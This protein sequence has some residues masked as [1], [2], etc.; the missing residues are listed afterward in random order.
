MSMYRHKYSD[1]V[2]KVVFGALVPAVLYL[3]LFL[4]LTYPLITTFSTHLWG[5]AGDGYQNYW[6]LWWVK[7]SLV[8]QRQNP[9]FTTMQHYPYGS[10]L[11]GHP[12]N[13]YSGIVGIGLQ[14]FLTLAQTYNAILMLSYVLAGLTMFWLGKYVTKSW[15]AGFVAGYV[16]T[17]SHHHYAYSQAQLELANIQWLPLY[18]MLFLMFLEKPTKL[19]A[20]LAALSLGLVIS[21]VNYHLVF[22]MFFSLI[23]VVWFMLKKRDVLFIVRKEYLSALLVFVVTASITAGLHIKNIMSYHH[24]DPILGAHLSQDWQLDTYGLFVPGKFWRFRELTMPFWIELERQIYESGTYIGAASI[25]MM[26]YVLIVR[27]RVQ[28]KFVSLWY[29]VFAF[30]AV[31]ALGRWPQF[32]GYWYKPYEWYLPYEYLTKILPILKLSGVPIRMTIMTTLSAAVICGI[33]VAYL[34]RQKKIVANV[35]V[36]VIVLLAVIDSIP[37]S[38]NQTELEV[39]KIVEVIGSLPGEG[40]VY[41]EVSPRTAQVY[42]QTLHHKP[43]SRGSLARRPKSVSVLRDAKKELVS[44][45]D[46]WTLHHTFEVDYYITEDVHETLSEVYYD[47]EVYIYSLKNM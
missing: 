22:L 36:G 32:G 14:T 21:V 9:W 6:N 42:Y 2:K 39:P 38:F 4:I 25:L 45:D 20:F 40:S 12:L 33:G 24:A 17:F 30:F 10:T 8:E 44:R 23:A 16:Y 26:I 19:K 11:L 7:R 29:V 18:M 15:W 28:S 43:I 46:F 41:D 3:L 47:G 13:I 37:Y 31:M 34:V 1:W 27:K 35:V 5:D